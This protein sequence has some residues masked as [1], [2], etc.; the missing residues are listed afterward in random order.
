MDI[1]RFEN[2][3]VLFWLIKDMCWML[4]WKPIAF[5]MIIPTV[6]LSAWIVWTSRK[7]IELWINLA[8]FFWIIAN[9]YWMT[10]EFL[11]ID[12]EF[13]IYASIPFGLGLICALFFIV[14]E[15]WMIRNGKLDLEN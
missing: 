7:T 6:I 14:K 3:H 5:M 4:F 8:V 2:W 11:G 15:V 13:K 1:R 10:V 12:I 9:S